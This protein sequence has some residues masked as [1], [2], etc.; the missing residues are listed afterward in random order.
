M[1]VL[2]RPA[3]ADPRV[4]LAVDLDG[5]ICL[6]DTLE[7]LRVRCA[8]TS[9]ELEAQRVAALARDKQ[10]EKI[11]LWERVGLD[12]AELPFDEPLLAD[13]AAEQARGRQLILVTGSAEGFAAA[14]AQ[15]F[16]IFAGVRGSRLTVNL[17]GPRKAA[18]LVAEFGPAGFDYLGDSLADLPVW[19]QARLG[20]MV[21]RPS[22]PAFAVPAEVVR[23][24][25]MLAVQPP[26][27]HQR[28]WATGDNWSQDTLDPVSPP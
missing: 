22:T 27:G 3:D 9:A 20:Y 14:V 18:A 7:W 19:A 12:L 1:A 24:P 25:S 28:L 26:P 8:D 17:T 2:K 13:L 23:L 5:T 6:A 15:R 10:S 16:P 11:F 21:L 4:P